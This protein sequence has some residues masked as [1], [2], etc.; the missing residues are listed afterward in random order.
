MR[1]GVFTLRHTHHGLGNCIKRQE[2]HETQGGSYEGSEE[3]DSGCVPE[4]LRADE[5]G[6]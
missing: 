4:A 5:H 2:R 3:R 6:A 1:D